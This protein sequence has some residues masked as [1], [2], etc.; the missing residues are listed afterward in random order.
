MDRGRRRRGSFAS[1]KNSSV[2]GWAF[3]ALLAAVVAF[4]GGASRYDAI[5]IMPLRALSALFFIPAL[6]H[7]RFRDIRG[8]RALIVLFLCFAV[9]V[10]IQLVPLPPSLWGHLPGRGE[11]REFDAELGLI[12]NWRPLT[13]APMRSWN[14][15]SS[16]V[17]PAVGLTLAIALGA[18]S[19][20][21]LKILL[22]LGLLNAVLG[23][24]QI[25][26]GRTSAL[27]FYEITNRGAP[28]GIFANEN[29]SA[30]FAACSL[31]IVTNLWLRARSDRA[32]AW[33]GLIYP[34]AFFL[35]L[36]SSLAS[37]SRAGFLAAILASVVSI[38][39]LILSPNHLKR[40]STGDPI[41]RWIDRH[42]RLVLLFPII[43]ITLTAVAFLALGRN[44]AFRD[45]LAKDSFED[46]RWS[47]WPVM[48]EMFDVH[49]MF[50]SGFGS[51]EQVYRIFEPSGLLMPR[52]INQAHNDW[53]QL[54]IEGGILAGL[55]LFG[56]I[57][58]VGRA[59]R[60]LYS[61]SQSRS[62]ALFWV[63][64]FAIIGLSS[65][66]DY[67]LRTPIFQLAGIWLLVAL[68]R[69]LRDAKAT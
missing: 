66:V 67:P 9:L 6:Y 44:P 14:V 68:S 59:V 32:G 64:I 55:I 51:F 7:L 65:I 69:D 18:S 13:L 54:I 39:M 29:H 21:L 35:I 63:G 52:Y 16:L 60:A 41:R 15:L 38:G 34:V 26:G 10:A 43:V 45:I 12:D 28:V 48:G 30:V 53:A 47:F 50:G 19:R 2:F 8:E 24:L 20:V 33:E 27:Y 1:L 36:L 61:N 25:M 37:G 11:L 49:W 23:M 57:F 17:V 3:L 31:M 22:A 40:R 62:A 46:L 42:P 4:T 58:W 56:L 5:Q